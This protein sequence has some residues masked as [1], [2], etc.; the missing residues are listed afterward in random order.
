MCCD[1]GRMTSTIMVV[2]CLTVPESTVSAALLWQKLD[3]ADRHWPSPASH[4]D[5]VNMRGS[6]L[7][8]S[9]TWEKLSTQNM[10]MELFVH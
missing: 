6:A 2:V 3:S 7:L 5:S 1:F 4:C 10:H 9:V 8:R